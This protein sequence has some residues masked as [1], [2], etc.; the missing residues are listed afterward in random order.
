MTQQLSP[1]EKLE[2]IRTLNDAARRN[3]GVSCRANVTIG[4]S[5]LPDAD[6]LAAISQIVA[7]DQFVGDNDPD[8]ER[9][10]GAVYR[11]ASGAWTQRRPDDERT[12]AQTVFWKIDYYDNSLEVGSEEPWDALKTAR[13]LTIMLATEY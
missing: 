6:R 2:R 4:F 9:D 12:I 8:G 7:F 13:V 5:S 3:P 1:A 10:F 11:L